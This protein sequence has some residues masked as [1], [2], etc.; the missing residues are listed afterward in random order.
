MSARY[1]MDSPAFPLAKTHVGRALAGSGLGFV[2]LVVMSSP[3]AHRATPFYGV[4]GCVRQM[5]VILL[6]AQS[7]LCRISAVW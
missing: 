6:A 1:D 7:D 5:L 4:N 2:W 3:F